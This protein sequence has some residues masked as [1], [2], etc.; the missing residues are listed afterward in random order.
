MVY[1][2]MSIQ[3]KEKDLVQTEHPMSNDLG[4]VEVKN[5]SFP[6]FISAVNNLLTIFY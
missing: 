5:M 6:C 4:N 2:R 3:N 1:F